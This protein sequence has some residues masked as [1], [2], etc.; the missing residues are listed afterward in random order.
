MLCFKA[1]KEIMMPDDPAV[2]MWNCHMQ[3]QKGY[4]Q[5]MKKMLGKSPE[6]INTTNDD[7]LARYRQNFG[8]L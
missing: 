2:F 3:D 5:D 8:R 7:K 1:P 4:R 6:H